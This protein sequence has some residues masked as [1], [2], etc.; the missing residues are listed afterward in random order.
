MQILLVDSG[1]F[2]HR[3]LGN[4]QMA[5][6]MIIVWLRVYRQSTV[7]AHGCHHHWARRIGGGGWWIGRRRIRLAP[8]MDPMH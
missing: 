6:L 1:A 5:G 8:A 7:A 2:A 3:A 4:D